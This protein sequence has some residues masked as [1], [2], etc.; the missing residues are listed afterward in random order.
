MKIALVHESLNTYGGAE[1]VLEELHEAF[2]SASVFVPMYRLDAFPA[3][4][5]YWD[6]RPTWMNRLPWANQLTRQFFP[7]YPFAM[8]SIDLTNYDL[9]IS[10]SFNFAHSVMTGPY[11]RHIC[12]CH[13]PSR[14]LWDFHN[15]VRQENLGKVKKGFILPFIPWLRTHD[16]TAAQGVDHW[17][18]TSRVVRDRI[19]KIYGRRSTIIPPPVKVGDFH[20]STSHEGYYLL[21]MR[22]VGWKRAD[23]AIQ[24]CNVLKLPLIVA[25]EGRDLKRLQAIAGPT[26]KFVGRVDGPAKAEL[27]AR[28]AAFILPAQED[29][30]ITPLEAMASGRPVIALMEGGALDTVKPG[31]TGEFFTEQTT[32]SLIQVL[33]DFDPS[34]YNPARI[35]EHAETF[36]SARF[37]VRIREFVDRSLALRNGPATAQSQLS[38][39]RQNRRITTLV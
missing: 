20:V 6:L 22:L 17:I 26:I 33:R 18:G 19:R 27:Y 15:Y 11:T 3:S 34:H 35:R 10:S 4:V 2:P 16:R 29:F 12:Y 23:I 13:S 9:V 1:K 36:D 5:Q 32:E 38:F 39:E 8:H 24:A 28:C 14:F 21:L 37:R 7:L 30:G 25:G 31:I